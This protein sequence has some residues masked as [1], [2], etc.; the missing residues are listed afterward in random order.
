M[1]FLL[2]GS[3]AESRT[4]GAIWIRIKHHRVREDAHDFP[5]QLCA[6]DDSSGWEDVFVLWDPDAHVGF[7]GA[8]YGHDNIMIVAVTILLIKNSS[9]CSISVGDGLLDAFEILWAVDQG[10]VAR[11]F[12]LGEGFGED[13]SEFVGCDVV[14]E[15]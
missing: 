10:M 5:F 13:G 2:A 8:F 1:T 7:T 6:V 4:E 9:H 11:G 12:A 3:S 15:G 14:D